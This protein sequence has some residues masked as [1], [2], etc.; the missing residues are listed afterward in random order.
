MGDEGLPRLY[1]DLAWLWPRLSPVGDYAAEA[2]ALEALIA[3]HV[4][5]GPQRVLE[6]G[7]GGGHTLWH[8]SDRGNGVHHCEGADLVGGDAGALPGAAARA[9]DARG[10]HADAAA[11]AGV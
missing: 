4:G 9:A 1:G 5:R 8:L 10:G 6:L 7:A 11:G 2:A 3:E